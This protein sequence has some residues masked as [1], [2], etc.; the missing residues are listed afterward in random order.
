ML[1]NQTVKI[2]ESFRN[3]F[4]EARYV[5]LKHIDGSFNRDEVEKGSTLRVKHIYRRSSFTVICEL[6][7]DAIVK[8]ILKTTDL[9]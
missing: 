2:T 1:N 6:L 4:G 8:T 9:S 5:A 3:A 7:D